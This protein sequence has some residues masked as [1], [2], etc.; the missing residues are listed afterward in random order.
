MAWRLGIVE[1][2]ASSCEPGGPSSDSLSR[3][4]IHLGPKS[5]VGREHSEISVTMDPW[6][7]DEPGQ[8]LK[9]LE[10]R[11]E[12]DGPAVWRGSG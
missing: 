8:A 6:W 2:S 9:Q 11:E 7:G 1:A 12:E 5:G 10:G 4:A 3:R